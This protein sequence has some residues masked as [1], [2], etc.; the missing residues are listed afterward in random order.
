MTFVMRIVGAL[1]LG[2]AMMFGGGLPA[3]P[4]QAAYTVTLQQ[5]GSNVVATGAGT[6]DTTDFGEGV[7]YTDQ[8]R[9]NPMSGSILTGPPVTDTNLGV[10]TQINEPTSFGVGAFEN[11]DSGSG[12]LVGVFEGVGLVIPADYP[13][14]SGLSSTV[15]WANQTFSSLGVTPGS[16]T[17][18]W[19][20]GAHSDF[21]Q[22]NVIESAAAVP[23]P[24]SA[25]LLGT[26]L[27]GLL[28]A[29]AIRRIRPEA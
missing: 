13:S 12:D 5:Q 2:P 11:A 9:M 16:Y 14:G 4:A 7:S 15:T 17:W 19:G 26:A 20:S 18:N 21:F 27:A 3:P 28:L 25:V 6:L 24:A 1:A 22:F 8:A 23:E 10:L 29:G